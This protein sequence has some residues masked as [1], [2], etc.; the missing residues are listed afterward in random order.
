M[1]TG[2]P[3]CN[4]LSL[5]NIPELL[6]HSSAYYVERKRKRVHVLAVVYMHSVV[7]TVTGMGNVTLSSDLGY[8][9]V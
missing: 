5:Y 3:F 2:L 7:G 9:R 6:M 1:Y 8:A 4:P